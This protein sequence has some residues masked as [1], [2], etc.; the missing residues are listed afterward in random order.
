[1]EIKKS[2]E[3]VWGIDISK[4]WLDISIG[5]KVT[6][7]EQK[8]ESIN[9]FIK[10]NKTEK[11]TLAVLESTGGYE[12]LAANCFAKADFVV[13]I[14]HPNKVRAYAKARGRLAKT[15]KLDAKIIEGYGKFIEAEIIHELPSQEQRELNTLS[16]RLA[17]LKETHHQESCR[18]GMATGVEIKRSHK[19]LIQV[20]AKE[21]TTIQAKLLNLIQSDEELNKKY[22]LLC[23]M[24]GVGPVLAM[25]LIAELPELGKIGKKQIAA[26]VGVAP[27]TK[28]SGKYAGKSSTQFG[29]KQVRKILYM[30]ALVA[31]HHNKRLKDF[32]QRLVAKGKLKKVALVAVMRKM[33]VILNAMVQSNTAFNT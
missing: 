21:I 11:T 16:G 14:A 13:H 19:K 3:Q 22:K 28:E 30:A 1:M 9:Q 18:L 10:E 2:Y 17:Q 7:I 4:E 24:K 25:T 15:D 29:R 31:A 33:L 27:I 8:E 6:R 23:T 20:L 5:G 12:V 32:Y 26:L